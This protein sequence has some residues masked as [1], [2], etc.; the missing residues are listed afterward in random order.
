MAA[1]HAEEIGLE[2]HAGHGLDFDTA[3]TIA[4]LPQVVELNIGH[5]LVGEAIFVGLDAAIKR[6][7]GRW[8]KAAPA[9]AAAGEAAMIVGIGSD[10]CDIRRVERTIARFGERFIE[11]CFTEIER[12]KSDRRVERAAS[13]AKRFAAKEACAKAL[14]TGLR[15]GVFW[16]DMGVVN[17]PGG[18]PTMALTGGAAARLKAIIPPG[19]GP[20]FM[21]PS[22][23]NIR[24]RKPL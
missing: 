16:R 15:R 4:E 24:W 12:R 3:R 13:Y 23:T 19:I 22:P 2:C 1:A 11:R 5:F 18:Q 14:G 21:S 17:K 10:L 9:P 20:K 6:M 8:T 7:R